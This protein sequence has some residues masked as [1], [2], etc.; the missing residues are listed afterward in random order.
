M[1]IHRHARIGQR[2]KVYFVSDHD[3]SGLDLQRS[4]QEALGNFNAPV[5]EFAR[6]GLTRGQVNDLDLRRFAIAVKP[7]DS[8]SKT[9]IAE[10]GRDCWEVDVLPASAL[11]AALEADIR[12]WFDSKQWARRSAEI[13]RARELL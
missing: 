11:E 2:A 13:E 9:Y 1:L 3:P 7:A 4:W 8:R 5:N 12:S 6:L 10:H